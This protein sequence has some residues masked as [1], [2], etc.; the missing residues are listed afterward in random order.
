M[1]RYLS[2]LM[3]ILGFVPILAQQSDY[4]YYYKGNR[5]DLTV[6]STRLYVVSEGELQPQMSTY[7]RAAEY[8]VSNTTKSYVYNHVVPLQK[9]RSTNSEVYFSTLEITEGLLATQYEALVEKVKSEDNVWQVMPSFK[10]NGKWVDVTNN[11]F[12]K[13][14]SSDDLGKLQEMA[15]LYG[16]EIVGYNKSMPLWYTLSCTSS[17]QVN[18]LQA[19][20]LFYNSNQFANCSPE[21]CYHDLARSNDEYFDQ[22]WNLKNTFWQYPG[23]VV[24]AKDI[25]A[26][27]EGA[28]EITKGENVVVAVFDNGVAAHHPDLDENIHTY[29]FNAITNTSSATLISTGNS[30]GHGTACAGI[31]AAEQDNDEGI[32][33]IAPKAKIM[34][35]SADLDNLNSQ[36]I[37]N[38]FAAA[39]DEA[40]VINC[41]WGGVS[42][43]YVDAAIQDVLDNGRGGRG[44]VVVFAA[45]NDSNKVDVTIANNPRVLSVGAVGP[46]GV[47]AYSG[48]CGSLVQHW[49]SYY[50]VNLD[51]VAPGVQIYTTDIPG[52]SGYNSGDYNANFGRTSAAAPHV[53]GVAALVLSAHPE[54]RG[55]DVVQIIERSARKITTETYT[56]ATDTVHWSGTWHEEVG[57]GLIDAAAAVTAVPQEV[58]VTHYRNKVIDGSDAFFYYNVEIENVRVKS[59][60]DFLELGAVNRLMVKSSFVVEKG[61]RLEIENVVYDVEEDIFERQ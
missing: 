9:Q 37:V 46:N 43:E 24:Y 27:V 25:D 51:I 28:W 23:M 38:G 44:T 32:S 3:G 33:G 34:S 39:C 40:D 5:I 14:K 13:L 47:R 35:I 15:S 16:I 36:Q 30:V 41:S 60:A 55:D 21:F 42:D 50:G 19:T 20:N 2:L 59:I 22:Q 58:L 31:I 6:D 10:L 12:V 52:T 4:Y 18:A 56:Y 48:S 7:A 45:G 54:L 8:T 29:S 26:N 11:F 53:A 1:K 49:H 17:S 57:Y 61:A